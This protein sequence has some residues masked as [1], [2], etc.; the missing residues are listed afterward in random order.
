MLS[1]RLGG[2]LKLFGYVQNETQ[3]CCLLYRITYLP[4]YYILQ[5]TLFFIFI[6]STLL[7]KGVGS[8][9]FCFC[10]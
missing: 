5:S 4:G 8:V 3:A 2:A 6:I 9:I 10:L 7:F 1:L